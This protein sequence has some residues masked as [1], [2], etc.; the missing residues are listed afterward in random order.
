[1]ETLREGSGR[2]L[3]VGTAYVTAPQRLSM[4]DYLTVVRVPKECPK[5]GKRWQ[6]NTFAG[7]KPKETPEGRTVGWC[8][9]CIDQWD[10]G[11]RFK[12]LTYR[13]DQLHQL[14]N[15]TTKRAAKCAVLRSLERVLREAADSCQGEQ[16][17]GFLER[18]DRARV[19]RERLDQAAA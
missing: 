4:A 7:F 13:A 15:E 17:N 2:S 19:L 18:L 5:C 3:N 14:V 16:R 11:L 6:G 12:D 10:S 8:D 9:V 1:M